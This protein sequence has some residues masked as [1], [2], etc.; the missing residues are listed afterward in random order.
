MTR[1]NI[2]DAKNRILQAAVKIFAQKSFDGSR[3][4]EIAAEAKV[5]KS[6]IYYHFKNKDEILEVLLQGFI[7]EYTELLQIA[8]N[9]THQ[10]KAAKLPERMKHHYQE[11][12]QQNAGLIRIILIDSLKKSTKKPI[13]Y[14]M[15]ETLVDTDQKFTS[16]PEAYD[17]KERLVAEFFTN[18]I[19]NCAYLCF[20]E[21]WI[22]YFD[23]EQKEFD[24]M[25]LRVIAAT[26]GVYHQNHQ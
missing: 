10:M 23:M 4:D 21:S 11:F 3:I 20:A 19:P 15:V 18:I 14:Q 17:R 22:D 26:H 2:P 16:D 8:Q 13:I 1:K 9:D 7:R 6:L 5:P 12:F 25:F 24:T